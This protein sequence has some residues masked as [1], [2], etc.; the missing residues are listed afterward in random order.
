M[1]RTQFVLIE[2]P[3]HHP[4]AVSHAVLADMRRR[5]E[6]I[7]A[8]RPVSKAEI[9]R[10]RIHVY[11][12]DWYF[13]YM[14]QQDFRDN[15]HGRE[16]DARVCWFN[17]LQG[18]GMVDVDG[19]RL[20]IYACNIDGRKTWYPETACTFYMEGETVRVRIETSFG[21]RVD[22]IGITPGYIDNVKWD[23]IKDTDLA[24]RCDDQGNAV[25]GLFA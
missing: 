21:G 1:P 5:G 6:V 3:E 13:K 19:H 16:F 20:A 4:T 18:C 25:T 17:V 2:R 14:A 24:F 8:E 11:A 7:T 23:S 22:V 12:D 15:Y 9:K 10:D